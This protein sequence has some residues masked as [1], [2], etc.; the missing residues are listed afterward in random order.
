MYKKTSRLT[1]ITAMATV[2]ILLAFTGC[3][4]KEPAA[5]REPDENY[6]GDF[7]PFQLEN[8][9]CVTKTASG[10]VAPFEM[11]MYFAPRTNEVEARFTYGIDKVRLLFN[12]EERN[13]FYDGIV[14]YM[15]AY[16]A[17]DMPER[18]PDRKNFLA[19]TPVSVSWGVFGYAYNAETYIRINYEYLEP[20]KPYMVAT[21]ENG[22][23]KEDDV[24]S[25]VMNLYF[26]PS[27][28][29]SL[30]EIIDQDEFQARVD[31]LNRQAYTW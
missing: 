23:S 19:R 12:L 31:E 4:S 26:T 14:A 9:M 29:E 7:N 11:E 5:P 3:V 15:E 30:V 18:K 10:G 20:G 2:L 21:F 25:P 17:G 24:S 22:K 8:A 6:L 1:V 13:A 27:Q 28:L 16:N